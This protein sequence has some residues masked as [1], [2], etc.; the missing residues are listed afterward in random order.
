MHL[1]RLFPPYLEHHLSF[2]RRRKKR[3][4]KRSRK[5]LLLW[6]SC[7]PLFFVFLLF[8]LILWLH[9]LL[10]VIAPPPYSSVWS[11]VCVAIFLS[12]LLL[13]MMKDH[14]TGPVLTRL[15]PH[16]YTLH[17]TTSTLFT[18]TQRESRWLY[19]SRRSAAAAPAFQGI[20]YIQH[21]H[22]KKKREEKKKTTYLGGI[23]VLFF[24]IYFFLLLFKKK[25]RNIFFVGKI[26]F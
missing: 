22:T 16:T 4:W 10:C 13:E 14:R 23:P 19:V 5:S 15:R 6:L 21:I 25:K 17:P 18:Y 24:F 9:S 26:N 3:A 7:L 8:L 1:P 11:I 12:L 20:V 2:M